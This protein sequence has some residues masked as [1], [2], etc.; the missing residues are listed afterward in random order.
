MDFLTEGWPEKKVIATLAF[1][2]EPCFN[3]ITWNTGRVRIQEGATIAIRLVVPITGI[4]NSDVIV[5][6]VKHVGP[7]PAVNSVRH[8]ESRCR[9]YAARTR[10]VTYLIGPLRKFNYYITCH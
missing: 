1:R 10:R 6:A 2:H 4:R 3:V 8:T 7:C 5:H 9:V